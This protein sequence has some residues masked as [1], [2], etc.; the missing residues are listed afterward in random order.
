MVYIDQELCKGC[1][2]CIDICPRGVYSTS[3]KLNAKGVPIPEADSSKCIKC[4]LCTLMCP[5]QVIS[6]EEDE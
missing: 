2:I 4:K 3:D 1:Y 5:D 6:I